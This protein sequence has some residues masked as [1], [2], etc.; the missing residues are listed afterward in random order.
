MFEGEE[1]REDRF[2]DAMPLAHLISTGTAMLTGRYLPQ[3]GGEKGGGGTEESDAGAQETDGEFSQ[4]E[5]RYSEGSG[6]GEREDR[7]RR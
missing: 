1:R 7:K 4:R 3:G 6:G 5:E 2:S